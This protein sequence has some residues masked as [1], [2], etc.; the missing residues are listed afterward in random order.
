MLVGRIYIAWGGDG[1]LGFLLRG[2]VA[3]AC[4]LCRRPGHGATL[5]AVSRAVETTEEFRAWGYSTPATSRAA[6]R[7]ALRRLL[8]AAQYDMS[9]GT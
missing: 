5:P 2:L 3:A 8:P 6:C 1:S 7:V 4:L 9:T